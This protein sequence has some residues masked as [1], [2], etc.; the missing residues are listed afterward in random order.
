MKISESLRRKTLQM[1]GGVLINLFKIKRRRDT[2]YFGEIPARYFILC[3]RSGFGEELR[4]IGQKWMYLYFSTLIPSAI[5]KLSPEYILNTIV[6]K[7]WMNIGLIGDLYMERDGNYVN[8]NTKMEGMT[9]LIGKNSF[10]VGFHQGII[11]ALYRKGVEIVD[12]SQSKRECSYRFKLLEEKLRIEGKGKEEY[13]KL[14][15]IPRARGLTLDE[16]LKNKVFNLKGN[17]IYFRERVIYPIE[18]TAIHLF[19]NQNVML[20]EVPKISYEF[21]KSVLDKSSTEDER[22][23]LLR[24]LMQA[25]GWGVFNII[26]GRGL[27]KMRIENPPYGLQREKDNWEF[28]IKMVLGYM[29]TIDKGYRIGKVAEGYKLLTVTFSV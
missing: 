12:V 29:R 7:V 25:M 13:D 26:K 27:V 20:D 22:L 1:A 5:K 15:N 16:M 17:K 28:L 19:S 14:N 3:E 4:K 18:N 8:V 6:R 9:E 24:N 2:L 21:F 23:R 10:L 11:N